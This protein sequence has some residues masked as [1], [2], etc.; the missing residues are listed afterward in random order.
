MVEAALAS[1]TWKACLDCLDEAGRCIAD[2]QARIA[3]PTRRHI[4]E[5]AADRLG[6]LFKART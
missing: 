6:I 2:H 1:R 5:E 4:L 3:K